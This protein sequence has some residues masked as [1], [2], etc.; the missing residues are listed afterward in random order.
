M[1]NTTVVEVETMLRLPAS[2]PAEQV[3]G[4]PGGGLRQRPGSCPPVWSSSDRLGWDTI[5]SLNAGI[6]P[7]RG[8]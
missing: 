5:W 2:K 3:L 6:F 1:I 8:G 4:V 7:H